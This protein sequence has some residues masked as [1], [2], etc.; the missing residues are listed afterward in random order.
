MKACRQRRRAEVVIPRLKA[1]KL[2]HNGVEKCCQ[3]SLTLRKRSDNMIFPQITF[4][5]SPLQPSS[6]H[7]NCFGKHEFLLVLETQLGRPS[8]V[9]CSFKL[10][11]RS[12]KGEYFPCNTRL[13]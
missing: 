1:L 9:Q 12:Q 7:G 11:W 4:L 13:C 3:D 2:K 8:V 10:K 6:T 5:P